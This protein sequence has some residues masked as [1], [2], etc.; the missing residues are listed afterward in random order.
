M[1]KLEDF[2]PAK[3]P[4]R[5]FREM[6]NVALAELGPLLT[7]MYEA[8]VKAGRPSIVPE[9]PLRAMLLQALFVRNFAGPAA[10]QRRRENATRS[11]CGNQRMRSRQRGRCVVQWL[12]TD[13][14]LRLGR[15]SCHAVARSASFRHGSVER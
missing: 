9:K 6:A 13:C 7:A 14:D 15:R 1:C 12:P 3:H 4:L 2:V 8:E 10:Q 5:A 11:R